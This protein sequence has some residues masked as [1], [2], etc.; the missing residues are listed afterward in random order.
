[1]R[2]NRFALVLLLTTGAAVL[3]QELRAQQLVWVTEIVHARDD[4]GVTNDIVLGTDGSV[5]ISYYSRTYGNLNYAVKPA[6]ASWQFG[7]IDREGDVG[8]ESS[9]VLNSFNEPEI[10]YRDS[11]NGTLKFA[12]WGRDGWK[13]ETWRDWTSLDDGN[14][15]SLGSTSQFVHIV[16]SKDVPFTRLP[17]ALWHVDLRPMPMR[18]TLLHDSALMAT[19]AVDGDRHAH[20]A[21]L[22]HDG[23]VRYATNASGEWVHSH[24]SYD[25]GRPSIAVDADGF[26]H[27]AYCE[28]GDYQL[29]YATNRLG[30]WD[31]TTIDDE[32]EC[33]HAAVALDPWGAV[34]ISYDGWS[35]RVQALR[36]ATNGTGSWTLE[37]ADG[38]ADVLWGSNAIA[39]DRFGW[40][41]ISYYD[42]ANRDLKY[43]TKVP[44]VIY[45]N[46]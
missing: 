29:K 6:R 46:R 43:A 44:L 21:Y 28:I 40:P 45:R 2:R 39:V 8:A 4:V 10:A 13:V 38:S 1:M 41:H 9:L 5:H 42:S 11:T 26:A 15:I 33:T 16:G 18:Q 36:Y 3:P 31:L 20:V 32:R 19:M 7:W 34:H 27:L 25:V 17:S 24:V 12:T 37:T 23:E 14:S 35:Q 30:R 22:T